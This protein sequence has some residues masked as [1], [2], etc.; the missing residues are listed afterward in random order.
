MGGRNPPPQVG[1]AQKSP[2]QIGLIERGL[3]ERGGIIERGLLE[4]GAIVGTVL[5]ERGGLI[6]RGLLE[7]GP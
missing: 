6:D 3:L 7:K 5:L 4:K 1:S 2:G